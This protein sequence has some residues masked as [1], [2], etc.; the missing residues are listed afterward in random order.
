M[1]Q[2]PIFVKTYDFMSWMLKKTQR[3]PRNARYNLTSW[4]ENSMGKF[5][6]HLVTANQ[7]PGGM[8][9]QSLAHA[10]VELILIRYWLRLAKDM[11]C[12]DFD[13]YAHAS[14]C[15]NEIGRLLGAWKKIS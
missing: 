13:A 4:L 12:L 11:Q 3:F 10:D 15:V 6:C 1:L 14:E 8:R 5:L 9:R 7:I 2:S